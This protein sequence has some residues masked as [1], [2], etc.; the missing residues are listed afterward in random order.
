MD[1]KLEKRIRSLLIKL[2]T[3]VTW[4]ESDDAWDDPEDLIDTAA[5]LVFEARKILNK[6]GVEW[7]RE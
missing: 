2:A 5:P 1:D 4:E 7:K 6:M 3:A